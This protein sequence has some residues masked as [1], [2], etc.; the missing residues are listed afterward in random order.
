M[1]LMLSKPMTGLGRK[2]FHSL[3]KLALR[4]DGGPAFPEAHGHWG[5]GENTGVL[6]ARDG[7][8]GQLLWVG[9]H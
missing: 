7:R 6:L 4:L 8:S 1:G 5:R 2:G 9:S 3:F